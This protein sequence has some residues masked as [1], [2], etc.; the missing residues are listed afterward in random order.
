MIIFRIS[1]DYLSEENSSFW[2]AIVSVTQVKRA[3]SQ[4]LCLITATKAQM[5]LH[6]RTQSS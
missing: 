2:M 4:I 6:N 3:N 5:D 1:K